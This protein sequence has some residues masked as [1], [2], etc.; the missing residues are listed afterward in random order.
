VSY[1]D[2]DIVAY[3][4][5]AGTWSMYFD[6]SDVAITGDVDAFDLQSDGTILM[7]FDAAVSVSG[8]GSVAD[9]DIVRFTPTSL[10]STTAGT[11]SWYFDGSDVG[12]T[13]TSEDIDLVGFAPDGRLLI[14]TTGN[15]GVTGLSSLTD[16]DIIAFTAT[17]LGST[18]AGTWSYYFDGSDVGLSDSSS[19]DT[20][21]LWIDNATNDLYL[22][23]LGAFSVTGVSGDGAD[24]F[25][26]DPGT[27]GTNTTCTFTMYW[28]GSLYGFAGE[29]ADGIDL[30]P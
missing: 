18:T 1:A 9:A 3:N 29:V 8:L 15:P 25:I 24:I 30:V 4:T 27:L 2:E 22:T 28:D 7:S 17:S 13:T 19:E 12:L 5:A 26:C 20:N 11:F 16:E 6:A 21:G 10:G 14:S 23:V